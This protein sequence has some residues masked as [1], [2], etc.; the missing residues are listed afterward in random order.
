[1]VRAALAVAEIEQQMAAEPGSPLL[2]VFALALKA[3]YR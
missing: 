1:M 2:L 3:Q